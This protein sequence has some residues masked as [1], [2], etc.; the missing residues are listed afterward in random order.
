MISVGF[1]W[2]GTML[3]DN[4]TSFI[5]VD[6]KQILISFSN[7][8]L[9]DWTWKSKKMKSVI[10]GAILSSLLANISAEQTIWCSV[11]EPNNGMENS[12]IQNTICNDRTE[13]NSFNSNSSWKYRRQFVHIR[14]DFVIEN[15]L[16]S[17]GNLHKIPEFDTIWVC[18]GTGSR[19]QAWDVLAWDPLGEDQ[20]A[21][22]RADVPA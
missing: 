6:W 7:E 19:N 21:K 4:G 12:G 5:S 2:F 8:F 17:I 10:F 16:N 1:D 11:Q 9:W 20:C 3:S 22:Q 14:L 18:L 13:W 15:P